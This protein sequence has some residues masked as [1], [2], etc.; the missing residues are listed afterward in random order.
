MP[1]P[2]QPS[3]SESVLKALRGAEK[4]SLSQR[5][6]AIENCL[7]L[8]AGALQVLRDDV[9]DLKKKGGK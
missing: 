4:K 8:M 2:K 9:L 6:T 1:K 3:L 5:F 7:C